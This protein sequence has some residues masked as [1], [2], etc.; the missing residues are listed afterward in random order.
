MFPPAAPAAG[1]KTRAPRALAA[2]LL[3]VAATPAVAVPGPQTT[4]VDLDAYAQVLHVSI[5]TGND[6]T[7]T[8][9]SSAPY[10]TITAALAAATADAT[11]TRTAI[12]IAAGTYPTHNLNLPPNTDLYGGF[13]PASTD[14]TRDRDIQA[15]PTILDAQG[16]DRV[17]TVSGDANT[18][19]RMD[20]LRIQGG[21]VRAPGGGIL[22]DGASPVL[23]NNVFTN[24]S[25]L[26]P[27][28]WAPKYLHET[29][30]DGGAIY[31]RNGGAPVIRNNLITEN[32]TETGRGGGIAFDH[33]CDGLIADN[34][35]I[36]NVAGAAADPMRSSDGRRHL[37]LQLVVARDHRQRRPRQLGARQQRRRRHLRRLLVLGQGPRQRHRHQPWQ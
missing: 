27:G 10:A 33:G 9:T 7:A 23:S 5:T 8:G 3:L 25:T 14:W 2:A 37:H 19:P 29:A 32:G 1:Q 22:I 26:T 16:E 28:N 34:A 20:G 24:N 4:P 6:S 31:C 12:L 15:H 18:N 35:I 30:H 13:D 17:L 36:S 21:L 11:T